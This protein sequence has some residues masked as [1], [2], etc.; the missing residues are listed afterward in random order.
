MS[1]GKRLSDAR[2][3]QIVEAADW[4]RNQFA[5]W[6]D[7]KVRMM[8]LLT[9]A[10]AD[11]FS[12]MFDKKVAALDK[13]IKHTLTLRGEW[14]DATGLSDDSYHYLLTYVVGLG[15]QEYEEALQCPRM[16]VFRG[17]AWDWDEGFAYAVPSREDFEKI[18]TVKDYQ[19]RA[20]R[21]REEYNEILEFEPAEWLWDQVNE[22]VAGLGV[23]VGGDWEAFLTSEDRL[24][25]VAA[26]LIHQGALLLKSIQFKPHC[27]PECLKSADRL[28][29]LFW[30]VRR[31]LVDYPRLCEEAA[32]S[33]SA[34]GRSTR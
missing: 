23:L 33:E 24:R 20:D 10:Q 34:S 17:R 13:A 7:V 8:A 31:W 15:R 25:R 14:P 1:V 6:K 4:A 9:A 32:S 27:V 29:H 3:W 16:V 30:D 26:D 2:F 12:A 22:V 18:P 28:A 19:S 21:L 11:R 5:P